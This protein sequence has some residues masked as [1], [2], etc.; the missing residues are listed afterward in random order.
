MVNAKTNINGTYSSAN[1]AFGYVS[2]LLC[3][4]TPIQGKETMGTL[5]GGKTAFFF[6]F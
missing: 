3:P 1:I 2:K 6:Y 5:L 4:L